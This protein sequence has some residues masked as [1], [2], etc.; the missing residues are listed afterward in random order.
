MSVK[1]TACDPAVHAHEVVDQKRKI[2]LS[3][4]VC[5]LRCAIDSEY[6]AP[7]EL[8]QG[9]SY[10]SRWRD[11]FHDQQVRLTIPRVLYTQGGHGLAWWGL[12]QR[13]W[14]RQL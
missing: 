7:A 14:F 13:I 12:Q 1:T 3:K 9:I 6:V 8:R 2:L 11:R 10:G 4:C 5:S